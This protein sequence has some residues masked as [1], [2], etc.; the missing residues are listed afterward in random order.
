MEKFGLS[1]EKFSQLLCR[2][3]ELIARAGPSYKLAIMK[4]LFV[5]LAITLLGYTGW[6][7]KSQRNIRT[8]GLQQSGSKANSSKH[9]E[10]RRSPLIPE[11]P[12]RQRKA[13]VASPLVPGEIFFVCN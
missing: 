13:S 12:N 9:V 4:L 7:Q 8:V 6:A 1:F 3:E 2:S 11:T 5:A 10:A